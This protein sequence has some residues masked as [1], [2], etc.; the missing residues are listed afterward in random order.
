LRHT[1]GF[2]YEAFGDS[3]VKKA[4]GV[5][6][7]RDV[8]QTLAEFASNVSKLPLAYQPGTTW[9]YGVSV[10]VLGRVIEVVS[11]IPFDQFVSDR[12]LRPLGMTSTGFFVT[13]EQSGRLAEAQIDPITGTRPS[14]IRGQDFTTKPKW[15]A[16]G[17]GM[18]STA[19]DYLRFSQMLLNGGELDGVRILSPHTVAHMI[20]NH[21]PPGTPIGIG[22]QF[23][24]L[25]PALEQGQGFGLGFA[26]R[27][28][29]GHNPYPGSVG[30]FYWVGATG[31]AFWVDPKERLIAIL[32]I[33]APLQTRHYRS[34]IR[35]LVYQALTNEVR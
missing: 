14:M 13:E 8:N 12:I 17:Q 32:M 22:G 7:V 27:V 23:G 15:L 10:D 34:R 29:P 2:T 16:G 26:V 19:A 28:T 35:N 20:S 31:T 4:Y 6:N 30:E 11:G 24:S 25:M 1:S 33:Q 18:V 5:A 21:L 3:L 9:E